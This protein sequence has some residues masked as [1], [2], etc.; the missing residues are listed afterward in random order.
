MHAFRCFVSLMLVLSTLYVLSAIVK[1]VLCT[2]CSSACHVFYSRSLFFCA[3]AAL[4][5]RFLLAFSL[6]VTLVMHVLSLFFFV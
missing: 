1:L 6:L 4:V 3:N 2:L 5:R